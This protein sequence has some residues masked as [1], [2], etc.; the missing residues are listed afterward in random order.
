MNSSIDIAF[1]SLKSCGLDKNIF[2]VINNLSAEDW[3]N[4]FKMKE[5]DKGLVVYNT[6]IPY[7]IYGYNDDTAAKIASLS[8]T[9]TLAYALAESWFAVI[10]GGKT[11]KDLHPTFND[12][13]RTPTLLHIFEGNI[14]RRIEAGKF[15]EDISD[16]ITTKFKYVLREYIDMYKGKS[17]SSN[18]CNKVLVGAT[19]N[20]SAF[21]PLSDYSLDRLESINSFVL[22]LA[23]LEVC[24]ESFNTTSFDKYDI[25]MIQN[26]KLH[27]LIDKKADTVK[28]RYQNIRQFDSAYD[29]VKDNISTFV[30][31]FSSYMFSHAE[32]ELLSLAFRTNL[33]SLT[34]G[35]ESTEVNND[36]SLPP[37]YADNEIL[38]D[39]DFELVPFNNLSDDSEDTE[40]SADDAQLESE[41]N[42]TDK[43]QSKITL[44]Q[45]LIHF[46]SGVAQIDAFKKGK[47]DQKD[48]GEKTNN[49]V[50]GNATTIDEPKKSDDEVD[51]NIF[52]ID[53]KKRSNK[54]PLIIVMIVACAI[55]YGVLFNSKSEPESIIDKSQSGTTYS[56]SEYR[57]IINRK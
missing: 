15:P 4:I 29:Y 43:S 25:D 39:E 18:E 47:C 35:E 41:S 6:L 16:F 7:L 23:A 49:A 44:S 8:S 19:S 26:G 33:N 46:I 32:Q 51:Y 34:T 37:L 3:L 38:S 52:V 22:F 50:D 1:D 9:D 24:I 20:S 42:L 28:M 21:P 10:Y 45:R 2:N 13:T 14:L 11:E 57:T 55:S 48:K 56:N 54:W 40:S 31:R 5:T 27:E 30:D 53:T 36:V 17:K 12:L